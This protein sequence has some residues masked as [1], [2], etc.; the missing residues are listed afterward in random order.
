[1]EVLLKES[2]DFTEPHQ[3]HSVRPSPLKRVPHNLRVPVHFSNAQ[4]PNVVGRL[5]EA[6]PLPFGETHLRHTGY[7]APF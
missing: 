6:P 1:M 4:N 7:V 2:V 3:F 5:H